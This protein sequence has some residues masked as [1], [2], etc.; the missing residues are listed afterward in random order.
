[1]TISPRLESMTTPE[2]MPER[3]GPGSRTGIPGRTGNSPGLKVPGLPSRSELPGMTGPA[4]RIETTAGS[5]WPAAFRK[6]AERLS[7]SRCAGR[8]VDQ[9]TRTA[10]SKTGMPAEELRRVRQD[11]VVAP[12]ARPGHRARRVQHA[13]GHPSRSATEIPERRTST[14][15]K[16]SQDYTGSSATVAILFDA[17]SPQP[18]ACLRRVGGRGAVVG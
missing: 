13:D 5:T 12:S 11:I 1:M 4:G 6:L 17:I 2:P 7:A 10:S 16:I 15:A 3:G 18:P 8:G 14:T 9:P